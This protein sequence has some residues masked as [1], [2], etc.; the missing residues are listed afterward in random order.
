MNDSRSARTGTRTYAVREYE[1]HLLRVLLV[2]VQYPYQAVLVRKGER[3]RRKEE[4]EEERK[5]KK[6]KKRN[7]CTRTK[8]FVQYSYSYNSRTTV[9]QYTVQRKSTTRKSRL[10]EGEG[11]DETT[12][13]ARARDLL[14]RC[15]LVLSSRRL[16]TV[17]YRHGPRFPCYSY[18]TKT[19]G[20][21]LLR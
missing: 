12:S 11:A 18:S 14:S 15:L 5:R 19:V 2:L 10:Y 9:Q 3:G 6:K 13:S 17:R 20:A 16:S 8:Y 21:F 7:Y 1:C 4:E